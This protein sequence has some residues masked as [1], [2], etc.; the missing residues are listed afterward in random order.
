MP[1]Q[2]HIFTDGERCTKK[3]TTEVS[4]GSGRNHPVKTW[5]TF[6]CEMHVYLYPA[7]Q[8]QHADIGVAHG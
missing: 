7:K 8:Y 2:C 3:A 4:I 1:E 6:S 5:R